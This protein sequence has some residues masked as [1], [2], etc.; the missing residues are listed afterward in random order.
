IAYGHQPEIKRV[1]GAALPARSARTRRGREAASEAGFRGAGGGTRT[2]MPPKGTPGFKPGASRQF[3][4]PG[5]NRVTRWRRGSRP[6][7]EDADREALGP[8]APKLV[9][10]R[11]ERLLVELGAARDHL[12]AA[13]DV[14]VL[15]VDRPRGQEDLRV[16]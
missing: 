14:A 9:A 8:F 12:L 7:R 13:G 1:P 4:H 6:G 5:R 16:R 2:R 3:R 11:R 10:E 15:D